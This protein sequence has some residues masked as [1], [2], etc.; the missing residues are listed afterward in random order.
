[1]TKTMKFYESILRSTSIRVGGFKHLTVGILNAIITQPNS[2]FIIKNVPDIQD[3]HVLVK[4]LNQ[5]GANVRFER[6]TIYA[7]TKYMQ[8]TKVPLELSKQV[9]GALYLLPVLL[10][11]FGRIDIGQ[12]GGCAIGESSIIG[13]RPIDHMLN[14]LEKFGAN[15][16]IADGRI[17]GLAS[18]FSSTTIDIM[19]YSVSKNE[20]NGPYVSGA[21]KTAL[22]A[23]LS[24]KSGKTIIRNIYPKPDATELIE[25]IKLLP[26]KV[27]FDG[28][29]VIIE[30]KIGDS[31]EYTDVKFEILGDLCEIISWFTISHYHNLP[32]EITGVHQT[33]IYALKPEFTA[34]NKMGLSFNYETSKRTMHIVPSDMHINPVDI[35]IKSA[36]IYSDHQPFYCLLLTRAKESSSVSDSVWTSR[37]Q[38]IHEMSKLGYKFERFENVVKIFPSDI[39]IAANDAYTLTAKDLRSAAVLVML[40]LNKPNISI[41]GVE[42][43]VRGYENFSEKLNSIGAKHEVV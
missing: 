8:S 36:E 23:A 10:G 42:H 33:C 24:V 14:V 29:N 12:C 41:E 9:H 17:L 32:L 13:S 40:A 26:Y 39:A 20:V 15:F 19:D 22:L 35:E 18:Q 6:N 27:E 3:T 7:N 2:K 30:R 38:H 37:F 11:R 28:C 5:F 21:T 25:F 34:F 31:Q 1:M 16:T 43:L 4:I